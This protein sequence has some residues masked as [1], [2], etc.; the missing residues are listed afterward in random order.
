M[1]RFLEFDLV[2]GQRTSINFEDVI[3][4]FVWSIQ[5]IG[6]EDITIEHRFSLDLF[7]TQLQE[8]ADDDFIEIEDSIVTNETDPARWLNW[9]LGD[10]GSAKLFVIIQGGTP[11]AFNDTEEHDLDFPG[12]YTLNT[13]DLID[14]R[15]WIHGISRFHQISD[16]GA[17]GLY[18]AE[19]MFNIFTV[20]SPNFSDGA[21]LART[22]LW[23]PN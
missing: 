14:P 9:K 18:E 3:G 15:R 21:G 8:P 22:V 7:N 4:S 19:G 1:S 20:K 17:N 16:I 2:N 6:D 11:Y 13:G 12:S 5:K 10:T 23:I